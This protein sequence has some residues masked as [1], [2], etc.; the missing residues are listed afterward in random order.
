MAMSKTQKYAIIFVQIIAAIGAVNWGLDAMNKNAVKALFKQESH[1]KIV[2][3]I[4]GAA[5][6]ATIFFALKWAFKAED[7][8]ENFRRQACT[9]NDG[10]CTCQ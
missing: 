7:K 6:L 5:G 2:Y 10:V 9:C 4:V 8:K 3:Y 1:Q